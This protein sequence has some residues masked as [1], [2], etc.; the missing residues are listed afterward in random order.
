MMGGAS[1]EGSRWLP[2]A[3]GARKGDEHRCRETCLDI[4][5]PGASGPPRAPAIRRLIRVVHGA[6]PPNHGVLAFAVVQERVTVQWDSEGFGHGVA[7]ELGT[8][9]LE[10]PGPVVDLRTQGVAIA[11][12]GVEAVALGKPACELPGLLAGDRGI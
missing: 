4:V 12:E 3:R 6:S 9:R 5:G 8:G 2:G 11:V 10:R 7:V 1:R